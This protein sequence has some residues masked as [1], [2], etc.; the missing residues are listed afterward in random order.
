MGCSGRGD[1]RSEGQ[2]PDDGENRQ[3]GSEADESPDPI[4]SWPLCRG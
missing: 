4:R 1:A 2:E 3:N